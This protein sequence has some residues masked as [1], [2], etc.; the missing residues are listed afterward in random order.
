MGTVQLAPQ[1]SRDPN[2]VVQLVAE[3]DPMGTVELAPQETTV[4]PL[5]EADEV[6]VLPLCI[7]QHAPSVAQGLVRSS[8]PTLAVDAN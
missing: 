6:Y 1:P 3:R 2:G 7:K 8:Q 4:M 5:E